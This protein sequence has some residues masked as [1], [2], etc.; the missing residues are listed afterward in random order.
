MACGVDRYMNHGCWN[1]NE[2]MAAGCY[3]EEVKDIQVVMQR[4][5]QC[6]VE[7]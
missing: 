5:K 6:K 4:G 3:E 1:V 7:E 2:G